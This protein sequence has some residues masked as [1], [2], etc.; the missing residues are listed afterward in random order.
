MLVDD[1][2]VPTAAVIPSDLRASLPRSPHTSLSSPFATFLLWSTA[3]AVA[4]A[5]DV[6]MHRPSLNA[7]PRARQRRIALAGRVPYMST[8]I[9]IPAGEPI[10]YCVAHRSLD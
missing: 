8:M 5:H 9:R 2:Y 10:G 4:L 6:F 7:I 1:K 3:A